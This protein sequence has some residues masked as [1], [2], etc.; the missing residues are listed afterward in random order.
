MRTGPLVALV[1]C[2]ACTIE[3]APSG[4]PPGP[5][6]PVDSLAWLEEDSAAQQQVTAALRVYYQR[7]SSR[8]WRAFLQSFWPGAIITTRWTPPGA[9]GPR[10]AV[11]TLDEFIRQG[12]NGPD[13]L[14]VFR[15]SMVDARVRRYGDL[16]DAWV[17]YR[18]RFGERGDSVLVSSGVDAFHLMRHDGQWRIVSLTFTGEV[19]ER[20]LGPRRGAAARTTARP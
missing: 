18:A 8:N 5:P 11:V 10:V 2:G 16:A 1:V 4:R 3:R 7:F 6:T 17:V 13:R 20:P 9:R 15:E 14:A 19:P 12:P